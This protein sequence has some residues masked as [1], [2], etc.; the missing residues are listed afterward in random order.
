MKKSRQLKIATIMNQNSYAGREYLSRLKEFNIDVITIGEHPENDKD[1]DERC[2]HLWS[3]PTEKELQQTFNFY[4]FNTLSCLD[5]LDFLTS[6]R[7]DLGIQGGT[8]ILKKDIIET[9]SLG[10]LN[11]HPGDLPEYRGCSA[12]EWQLFE[13]KK[14]RSTAHLID[15]GID[16]GDII[17]K[18]TLNTNLSS[19]NEFRASIY[20]ETAKFVK[21]IIKKLIDSPE[22]LN[23]AYKQ[24]EDKAHYRE[25]IGNQKIIQIK[26]GLGN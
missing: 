11:F 26:E 10:I 9:F 6:Q 18:K 12:P 2:G 20:P 14:I 1:E 16:S 7:Y 3:P 24:N 23:Q 25:Y 8:G 22:I 21:I 19:Y 5:L 17:A 13:G 4:N 15:E